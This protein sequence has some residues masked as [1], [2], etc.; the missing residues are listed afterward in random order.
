MKVRG[1]ASPQHSITLTAS[2]PRAVSLYLSFMSADGITGQTE[3]VLDSD[4]GRILDLIRCTAQNLSQSG[5]G[6]RT[7]RADLAL[8]AHLCSR[9][10]G[11]LLEQDADCGSRKQESHDTVF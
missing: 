10:G 5:R 11:V 4:L 9:D 7:R 1:I 2:P 6:H 3:I 8:A